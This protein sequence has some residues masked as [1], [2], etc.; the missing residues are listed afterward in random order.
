MPDR[1]TRASICIPRGE[2]GVEIDRRAHD[3]AATAREAEM[4]CALRFIA[5]DGFELIARDGFEPP[6]LRE[7]FAVIVEWCVV[8]S[9]TWL[10]LHH[11]RSCHKARVPD[12]ARPD[13]GHP[14]DSIRCGDLL[15]RSVPS[16][17]LAHL[18]EVL[19][20]SERARSSSACTYACLVFLRDQEDGVGK[21]P[22]TT[23]VATIDGASALSRP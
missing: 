10:M 13:P 23:T 16:A 5:R 8:G 4:S 6:L 1:G 17:D 22:L 21:L 18:S 9:A 11:E 15:A 19:G 2:V 7:R 3:L 14:R 20:A 12:A